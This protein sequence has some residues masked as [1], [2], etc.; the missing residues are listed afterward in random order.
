MVRFL[1]ANLI[2]SL[3]VSNLDVVFC[4]N[5]L[6]YFDSDVSRAVLEEIH[7]CMNP[8]GYLFL[9]HTESAHGLSHLFRTV[10]GPGAYYY[11]RIQ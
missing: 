1:H 7:S 4:R 3:P 8:G 6:I 2:D 9:G 5:V 11:E 10:Y